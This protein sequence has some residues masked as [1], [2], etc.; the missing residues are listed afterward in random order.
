VISGVVL[1]AGTSSRLGRPK[2][3]LPLGRTTILRT[4]VDAALGAP[5][6]EVVVVL[7]HAADQVRST[8][9]TVD[10]LRLVV[11]ADFARGQSTSLHAGLRALNDGVVA[12]VVLLGDQPGIR[13]E[14][15]A[16][17]VRRYRERRA[18]IV[19]VSYSGTPAH[20]TLLARPMWA[21][22]E[23]SVGDRGARSIIERHGEDRDLVEV[24]GE[25]PPDVDT[26]S[27]YRDV[28]RRFQ[29]GSL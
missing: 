5:L 7:G 2:Q 8:L 19:Q 14:H 3:L 13:S 18:P 1:A 27:D 12:M 29:L 4:V 15:I 23:R 10:R 21:E 25:P 16:A 20:P 11:N 28:L 22:V 9:P 26:E 24:T 6:D 17:M